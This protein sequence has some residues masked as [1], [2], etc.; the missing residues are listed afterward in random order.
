M[1]RKKNYYGV[2]SDLVKDGMPNVLILSKNKEDAIKVWEKYN[3]SLKYDDV[4]EKYFYTV[5]KYELQKC[6]RQ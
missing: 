5:M 6:K 1:R 3:G 4:K 2:C